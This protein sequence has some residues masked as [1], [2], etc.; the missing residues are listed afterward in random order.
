MIAMASVYGQ[1]MRTAEPIMGRRAQD[2]QAARPQNPLEL[3]QRPIVIF[4]LHVVEHVKRRNQVEALGTNWQAVNRAAKQPL[5]TA[6]AREIERLWRDVESA[7]S[8]PATQPDR[9]PA[10][11]TARVENLWTT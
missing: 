10:R 8:P 7:Y 5:D 9:R 3:S 4:N 6:L 1:V 2:H 11:T